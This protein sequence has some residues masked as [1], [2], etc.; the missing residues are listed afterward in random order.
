MN[1]I[2]AAVGLPFRILSIFACVIKLI[3]H[4]EI[5]IENHIFWG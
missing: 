2:V 5:S 3:H 4:K 1:E